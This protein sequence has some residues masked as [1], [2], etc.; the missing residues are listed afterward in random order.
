MNLTLHCSL[1]ISIAFLLISTRISASPLLPRTH[2][3][4]LLDYIRHIDHRCLLGRMVDNARGLVIAFFD[5]AKLW[6]LAMEVRRSSKVNLRSVNFKHFLFF[7]RAVLGRVGFDMKGMDVEIVW[8][9][10]KIIVLVEMR[11]SAL[12]YG[13]F[14]VVK[15]FSWKR[16][17]SLID[18][19]GLK[20]CWAPICHNKLICLE[21]NLFELTIDQVTYQYLLS[22]FSIFFKSSSYSKVSSLP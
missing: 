8:Q 18:L 13:V 20:D 6:V 1:R 3:V 21:I 16:T 11:V 5:L 22:T 9:R 7:L 4:P 15:D 10:I 17:Y 19:F 2:L 14:G 12:R